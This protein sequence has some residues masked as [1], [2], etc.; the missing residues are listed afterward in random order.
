VLHTFVANVND[1][2]SSAV[3]IALEVGQADLGGRHYRTVVPELRWILLWSR[4]SSELEIQCF[5]R[6]RTTVTNLKAYTAIA[7][8]R[9]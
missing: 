8:S 3:F 2:F 1:H 5:D 4:A 6:H 7:G 9:L